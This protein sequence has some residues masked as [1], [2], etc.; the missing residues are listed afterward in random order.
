[1]SEAASIAVEIVEAFADD[2]RRETVH[3]PLGASVADALACAT[4]ESAKR[5]LNELTRIDHIADSNVGVWGRRALATTALH[6]GDRI[7]LYRAVTADAKT[8]RLARAR[9]QGYR[10]QGRTRRVAQS[11]K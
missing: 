9:E 2:A 3:V 10:W 11:P 6:D 1:M 7:E 8:A 4:S 5:A